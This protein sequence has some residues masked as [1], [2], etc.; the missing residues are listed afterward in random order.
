MSLVKGTAR[1]ALP[2]LT[3]RLRGLDESLRY[4]VNGEGSWLGGT[5]MHAGYPIPTGGGDYRA[6][7][8]HLTAE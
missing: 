2:C 5:L 1:A 8:L 3:L 6:I 4:R 7:Q